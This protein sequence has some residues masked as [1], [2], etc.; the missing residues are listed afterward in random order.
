MT[1]AMCSHYLLVGNFFLLLRA[2]QDYH[3]CL[4]APFGR[5]LSEERAHTHEYTNT[6]ICISIQAGGQTP[7]AKHKHEDK[8]VKH[9]ENQHALILE[10]RWGWWRRLK[11]VSAEWSAHDF[12]LG[13]CSASHT[14]IQTTYTHTHT[15]TQ[16]CTRTFIHKHNDT[17]AHTVHIFTST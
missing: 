15:H 16:T 9:R 6:Y 17:R 2:A 3:L 13:G 14:W 10:W 7:E 12:R 1:T 5:G 11:I 4:M 8:E